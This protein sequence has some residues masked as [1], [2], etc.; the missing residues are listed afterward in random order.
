[1]E[2]LEI[3]GNGSVVYF[4]ASQ[5]TGPSIY[6]FHCQYVSTYGDNGNILVPDTQP[7]LWQITLKDFQ[8]GI[9]EEPRPEVAGSWWGG[10]G[11]RGLKSQHQLGS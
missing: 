11:S 2:R 4:N 8:V 6:S 3:H 10:G 1:M 7:S 9:K 5:I